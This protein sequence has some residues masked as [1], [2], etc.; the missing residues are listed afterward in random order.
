[1]SASEEFVQRQREGCYAVLEI[2]LLFPA[3]SGAG[4]NR[5]YALRSTDSRPHEHHHEG[6]RSPHRR[7][8]VQ[9]AAS[10]PRD[11]QVPRWV[12]T[13]RTDLVEPGG[14]EVASP[15]E[16]SITPV[17]ADKGRGAP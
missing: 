13:N 11:E 2:F 7:L 12:D 6:V 3:L 5:G 17:G 16:G 4:L 15:E 9:R 8:A 1:M 10:V 14:S